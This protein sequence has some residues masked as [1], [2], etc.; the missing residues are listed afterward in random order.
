MEWVQYGRTCSYLFTYILYF[1]HKRERNWRIIYQQ[2]ESK[3][4]LK[5]FVI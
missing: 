5:I 4:W 3:M 2:S 1:T